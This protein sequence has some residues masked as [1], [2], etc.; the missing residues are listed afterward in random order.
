MSIRTLKFGEISA[1][2]EQA[3]LL[4][5][6]AFVET[7]AISS[8]LADGAHLFV[9]R[10]G[11]GKTALRYAVLNRPNLHGPMLDLSFS[12]IDSNLLFALIEKCHAV[13]GASRNF[14]LRNVWQFTVGLALMRAL[15]TFGRLSEHLRNPHVRR[16]F[17]IC[18]EFVERHASKADGPDLVTSVC[19]AAAAGIGT[20]VTENGHT[21][22]KDHFPT[23][24][25]YF[26]A[27]AAITDLL[28]HVG[29]ATVLI[30]DL[31]PWIEKIPFD[32]VQLF[33]QA[34]ILA[35][36]RIHKVIPAKLLR[37]RLL[38]PQSVYYHV[39]HYHADKETHGHRRIKWRSDDLKR[40]ITRRIAI[41]LRV[42]AAGKWSENEE[43]LL[44]KIFDPSLRVHDNWGRDQLPFDFILF[45]SQYTPRDVLFMFQRIR[46]VATAGSADPDK[47]SDK[48]IREGVKV[49]C[50]ELCDR[51]LNEYSLRCPAI[52]DAVALFRHTN[53]EIS[54]ETALERAQSLD[55][56]ML[57]KLSPH[58]C[59]ELLYELGFLGKLVSIT[60]GIG[61]PASGRAITEIHYSHARPKPDFGDGDTLIVHPMFWDRYE[62]VP[63]RV[64]PGSRVE[65]ID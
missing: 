64:R 11:D 10:K 25:E 41:S 29:S 12:G 34:L 63:P 5:E 50:Y 46:E 40:L 6:G 24:P 51:M 36:P 16:S 44:G 33:V 54:Y 7:G 58:N 48:D 19:E 14:L 45:Y 2:K 27:E 56:R 17:D 35:C 53:A 15:V 37:L 26:L 32:R 9:A 28:E 61:V 49:A 43:Y 59:L 57:E 65:P 60:A 47:F 30:D 52:K 3:F 55:P 39:D 62:I 8:I 4:Q 18:R 42:R 13:S 21:A 31:D 23:T 22:V 1:E 20:F 38:L